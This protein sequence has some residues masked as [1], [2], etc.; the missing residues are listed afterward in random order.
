MS[1]AEALR[2]AIREEREPDF[3]LFPAELEGEPEAAPSPRVILQLPHF[4][5]ERSVP[6]WK[7][8]LRA[9]VRRGYT[10]FLAP[11]YG[12]LSLRDAFPE[13]EFIAGPY[14]YAVN[15]LAVDF[16]GRH[17]VR[18]FVLSPDIPPED[19]EPVTRFGGRLV[20]LNVPREMFITRLRVPEGEYRLK[21]TVFRPR[22]LPEY[23]VVEE[24]R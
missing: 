4:V 13:A 3:I 21:D 9:L 10:R 5:S 18:S 16:L 11:T 6:A 7:E 22:R 19:A 1:I 12:W 15:S 24:K 8:R 2:Q 17:G 14:C 20:P 23:T